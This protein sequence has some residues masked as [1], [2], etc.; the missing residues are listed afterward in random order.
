MKR[1]GYQ[2]RSKNRKFHT[3]WHV[4][5]IFV[6]LFIKSSG[7]QTDK[8]QTPG[9][10]R[11]A[12]DRNN[13]QYIKSYSDAD[14]TALAA[15]YDS[16]GSRLSSNGVV[17]LGREKI[18]AVVSRFLNN[19][20]PVKVSLETV[21]LWVVDDLAYETGKWTYTYTPKGKEER[22]SGSRYVTIWKRQANKDL[23]MLAD[24]AVPGT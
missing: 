6:V 9:E 3:I 10:V 14:A 13:A 11:E 20:G 19:V 4:T 8:E 15:V 24:M 17:H 18:T 16:K 22:T 23:K 2:M 5:A 1:K 12:I 21:D 7:A